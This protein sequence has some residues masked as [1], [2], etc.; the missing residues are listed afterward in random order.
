MPCSPKNNPN[1][2]KVEKW[3]KF[4]TFYTHARALPSFGSF[5]SRRKVRN[6]V[7]FSTSARPVATLAALALSCCGST[8][9]PAA[10][11][12]SEQRVRVE[13]ILADAQRQKVQLDSALAD[14]VG[15]HLALLSA[16]TDLAAARVDVDTLR[17]QKTRT[18]VALLRSRVF[19]FPLALALGIVAGLVLS[20]VAAVA[21]F[22]A[23]LA[24]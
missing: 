17:A 24:A 18:E 7:H 8:P 12:T 1:L 20:R 19:G 2:G 10:A 13:S 23:K 9:L 21:A 4:A 3:G 22:L 16:Q 11:L 6:L 15:A 5:F 14:Q